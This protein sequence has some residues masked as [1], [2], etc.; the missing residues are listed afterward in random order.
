MS[1][2]IGVT[3]NKQTALKWYI[4]SSEGIAPYIPFYLSI[5]KLYELGI[6]LL[7]EDVAKNAKKWY[8]ITY[9]KMMAEEKNMVYAQ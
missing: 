7:E 6:A 1:N 3:E 9:D 2:G 5:A 8:Q 4:K